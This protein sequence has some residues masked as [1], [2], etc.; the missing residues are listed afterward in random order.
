MG[1]VV[2]GF[3]ENAYLQPTIDIEQFKPYL[4]FAMRTGNNSIVLSAL[5]SGINR[6]KGCHFFIY[7]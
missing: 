7:L 5:S 3:S 4:V 6:L 1:G 2:L